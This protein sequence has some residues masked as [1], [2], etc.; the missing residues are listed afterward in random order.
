MLPSGVFLVTPIYVDPPPQQA[1]DPV[2]VAMQGTP[3]GQRPGLQQTDCN[4]ATD[5]EAQVDAG[6]QNPK[7]WPLRILEPQRHVSRGRL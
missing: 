7:R 6:G 4:G 2:C 1:L 5:A 3:A